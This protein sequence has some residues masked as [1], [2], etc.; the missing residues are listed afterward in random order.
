[1][2]NAL[3]HVV[4]GVS[5]L[6]AARGQY[7]VLVGREP[8]W[9]GAHPALGTRNSLFRL[10]NTYLELLAPDPSIAGPLGEMLR[11]SL[12][13]REERPF[14]LALGVRDLDQ[15]VAR[16]E[17]VGL[18][19][20]VPA[21][22]HGLD[23]A[24]GR[25]RDWRSAFLDRAATRGLRL[26]LIEHRSPPDALPIAPPLGDARSVCSAID[27]V[28]VFTEDLAASRKLW[29]DGLGLTQAWQRDFPERRTRNLGLDLAGITVELIERTDR[30]AAGR[31]DTLWGVALRV[32][33]CDRAAMRIRAAGIEVDDPRP[34]LLGGTQV[35]TVRWRGT[36]ALLIAPSPA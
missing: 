17:K 25:R 11:D 34:G 18:R 30:S 12:G 9:H 33:D 16:A 19:P 20:A 32:A 7:R 21:P 10:D 3:D 14:A 13:T 22:G 26:F 28:V 24:S 29:G 23:Q 35:A 36:P 5:D 15:A 8:S 2:L 6:D 1:M 4:L 31:P 27:H